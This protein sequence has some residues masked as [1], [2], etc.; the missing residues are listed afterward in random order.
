MRARTAA[1]V[2]GP[3]DGQT[4]TWLHRKTWRQMK[5]G[6]ER[7]SPPRVPGERAEL[8]PFNDIFIPSQMLS[9][10]ELEKNIGELAV[11]C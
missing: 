6:K 8:T 3:G 5:E 4:E 11:I 10:V 7:V 2:S 9:T 1:V